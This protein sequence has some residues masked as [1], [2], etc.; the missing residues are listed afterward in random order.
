M[1]QRAPICNCKPVGKLP[2]GTTAMGGMLTKAEHGTTSQKIS[3]TAR[4]AIADIGPATATSPP[5]CRFDQLVENPLQM[6]ARSR[7][8]STGAARW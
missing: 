5:S 4:K 6:T 8:N 7:S 3:I 2:P 1:L